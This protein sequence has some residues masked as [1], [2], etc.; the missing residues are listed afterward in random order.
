L[1]HEE[2][3]ENDP[4]GRQDIGLKALANPRRRH[5]ALGSGKHRNRRRYEAVSI[6][7]GGPTHAEKKN[8][9]GPMPD[10]VLGQGHKGERSA[11]TLVVGPQDKENI[12]YRHDQG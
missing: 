10:D 2:C 11:F 5:N 4:G 6:E 3:D 8:R 9:P 12:F 1:N 7:Q